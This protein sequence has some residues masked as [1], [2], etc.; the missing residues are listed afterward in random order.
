MIRHTGSRQRFTRSTRHEAAVQIHKNCA[1]VGTDPIAMPETIKA[2][3]GTSPSRRRL[4]WGGVTGSV[5][6]PKNHWAPRRLCLVVSGFLGAVKRALDLDRGLLTGGVGQRARHFS[7]ADS[8]FCAKTP[9]S[10]QRF[11]CLQS[12]RNWREPRQRRLVRDAVYTIAPA[13]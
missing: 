5:T 1:H 8:N 13:V 3:I 2:A 10:S 12:G 6:K 4:K 7:P 11:P 9:S